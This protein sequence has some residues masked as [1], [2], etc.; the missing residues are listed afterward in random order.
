MTWSGG[1]PATEDQRLTL[2][3]SA[4][5]LDDL[6][7]GTVRATCVTHED[8]YGARGFCTC[9]FCGAI[10]Y[11]HRGDYPPI[12]HDKSCTGVKLLKALSAHG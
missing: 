2:D 8:D 12:L 1:M 6:Y 11:Q 3:F 4:A 7:D 5:E 10:S 9:M